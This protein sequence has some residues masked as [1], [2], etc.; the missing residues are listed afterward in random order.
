MTTINTQ[1]AKALIANSGYGPVRIKETIT[2]SASHVAGT[3]M[4]RITASGKLAPYDA[5]NSDGTEVA[6]AVLLEA[7]DATAADV[8]AVAAFAGVYVEANVTGL[9]AAG[10]TALEAKGIYFK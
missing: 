5:L 8:S 9:D 1:T 3:V 6:I 10:K 7:A 2:G 4:G